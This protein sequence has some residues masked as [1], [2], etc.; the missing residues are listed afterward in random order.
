MET[1]FA[2]HNIKGLR[3]YASAWH[4][5][6]AKEPIR[7]PDQAT[8][9]RFR[10]LIDPSSQLFVAALDADMFQIAM[11]DMVTSLQT[12]LIEAGETN[13]HVYT[14]TGTS[15]EA[16][17]FTHTRHTPTIINVIANKTW[18][19]RLAP[20]QQRL[21]EASHPSMRE[22]GRA[23]RA[24]EERMLVIAAEDH[25]TVIEP[26]SEELAA[27]RSVGKS[28]HRALVDAAGGRAQELYDLVIEAK[29]AYTNDRD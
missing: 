5:I 20:G 9:K 25:V 6:Y 2:E 29:Q 14:I 1:L 10:A 18:W 3:I 16:P 11:T 24:D 13:A 7:T 17:Y 23:L 27:W 21:V 28:T 15:T 19:D 12:G 4:G 8:G 26:T 22:S